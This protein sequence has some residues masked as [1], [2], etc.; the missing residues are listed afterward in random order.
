MRKRKDPLTLFSPGQRVEEQPADPPGRIRTGTYRS[1]FRDRDIWW[2][3]VDFD[4]GS[5][6]P[7]LLESLLASG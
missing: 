4:D 7:V 5:R 2:A 1:C 3:Q 6:V